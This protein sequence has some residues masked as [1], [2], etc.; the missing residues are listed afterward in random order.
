MKPLGEG[1]SSLQ[2]AIE[3]I[4]LFEFASNMQNPKNVSIQRMEEGSFRK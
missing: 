4:F 1:D 2:G 3:K